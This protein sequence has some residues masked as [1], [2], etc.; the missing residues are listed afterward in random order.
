MF[1]LATAA[2]A[3]GVTGTALAQ[4]TPESVIAG[5]K[6]A[7]DL[8][9][10]VAALMKG[11]VDS[12]AEVKPYANGAKAMV[13][14]GKAIPGMFPPGTDTGAT[15]ALP[16]V[17][18]DKAGFEKAAATFVGNAEKLQAAADS[19]DKAAFADAFKATSASCGACHNN[20]RAK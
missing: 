19:G 16:A 18:S 4:A 6:A 11:A 8:Q 10:A 15:K 9:G 2:L 20:Y 13:A 17:W 12:G 5:R 3:T 1:F 7:Y 14:W